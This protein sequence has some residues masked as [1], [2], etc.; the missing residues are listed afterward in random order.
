[1]MCFMRNCN[2]IVNNIEVFDA[3]TMDKVIKYGVNEKTKEK[4]LRKP[5][6]TTSECRE[7]LKLRKNN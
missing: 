7:R 3:W 4:F 1:M 2:N 6:E 5:Y